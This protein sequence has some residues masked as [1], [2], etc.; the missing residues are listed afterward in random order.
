MRRGFTLV[1]LTIA[2]VIGSVVVLLAYATM[3]AGTDVQARVKAARDADETTAAFRALFSDA[4]RHA[5]TGDARDARGLHVDTDDNGHSA[6]LTF[7]SRGVTSP[8]GG[9]GAWQ[10]GLSTDSSGVVLDASSLDSARA[11]LRAVARGPQAFAVRFLAIDDDK[12]RTGWNDATRLPEAI[13]IRFL[14]R[15]GRETMAPLVSRT[16]PVTGL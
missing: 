10:I 14:D 9:T 11:P 4:V 5:V 1:E 16:A 8:L 15:Q 2:L 6:H 13:E 7:V 3:R 12:W